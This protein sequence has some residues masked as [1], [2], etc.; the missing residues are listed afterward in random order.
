M[1][2]H[3]VTAGETV[4]SIAERYQVPAWTIIYNNELR[5]PDSWQSARRF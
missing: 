1:I 3:V 2:I 5:S 4:I